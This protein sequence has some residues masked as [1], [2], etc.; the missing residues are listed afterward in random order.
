MQQQQQHLS[1]TS[2]GVRRRLLEG[3]VGGSVE[4]GSVGSEHEASRLLGVSLRLRLGGSLGRLRL[5]GR[6]G[7]GGHAALRQHLGRRRGLVAVVV[8]VYRGEIMEMSLFEVP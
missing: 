1:S 4:D 2:A 8:L 6:A 7:G 5:L 3:A